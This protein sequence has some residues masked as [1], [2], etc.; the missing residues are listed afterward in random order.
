MASPIPFLGMN[1]AQALP[2]DPTIMYSIPYN[3]ESPVAG[4]VRGENGKPLVGATIKVKSKP[5]TTATNADGKFSIA[6]AEDDILI[7]S[8]TGY[9]TQEVSV[10]RKQSIQVQLKVVATGLD[11]VVVIGYGTA[12]KSDLTGSVVSANLEA[13]KAAP[14]TNLAQSLQGVAP[15]LNIGQ[16]NSAGQT[17]DIQIR[18]A[19]TI[20]G[21]ANVLIVLDGII[22]N[23]SLASINPDDIA[24]VDVLKDASSTAIYGAQAANGVLL[25]TSKK[26]KAGRTKIS[27]TGAYSTQTPTVAMRPLNREEFI[28]KVRDLNYQ[29]AYLAPDYKTPNP[30]YDVWKDIEKVMPPGVDVRNNDFDWWGAGTKTGHVQEHQLS[31]SG[32]SEKLTYLLSAAT[33][34][35]AGFIINDKF[36]RKSFRLNLDNTI[37]S[38]LKIGI[39][40]FA[41]FV[42][43]DGSEPT[44]NALIRHSP[45][46]VPYDGNG[47]LIPSPTATVLD[48]PFMTYEIDDLD[49]ENSFFGN[50]YGEIKFPFIKGLSYRLNFGN[51]YRIQRAFQAN[52]YGAGLTGSASRNEV[53]NY[54]YTVDNIF[55]YNRTFDKIH[56]LSATLLYS[57]VERKYTRT[58]ASASNFPN[59]NL[60]YNSL[61]Q[62]L[63]QKVD[64]DAARE[65]M[66]SQMVRINYKLLDRYLVTGTLRRDGFSGFASNEKWATFPSVA[67]GWILS[68][69]DFFK[70]SWIN[71]LKLR[72]SYGVNGNLIDRYKSLARFQRGRKYVFGD[73][74]EPVFGQ[75]LD[76]MGNANLRWE[77]TTGFNYGIDFSF[78]NNRLAGSVEAYR[79]VTKDLLFDVSLPGVT[80]IDE[81]TTNLGQVNNQGFELTLNSKNLVKDN[82]TWNTTLNFST[83]K[84][85]I[86][87]LVGLDANH[88]GIEDDLLSD[89]LF[90]GHS[91]QSLRG[92][93]SNGI[94]QLGED[95]PTGYY[96]GTARIIDQNND[97]KINTEDQIIL[98]KREPTF[99]VSLLNTFS[100]K[101]FTLSTFLNAVQGGKDSYLGTV[102]SPDVGS[103]LGDNSIRLNYFAG[104]DYWSPSNPEARFPRSSRAAAATPPIYANRNFVRLQDVTLSYRFEGGLLRRLN[105]ENLSVYLNGKN[106][107]T[108]TDWEGWDPE[109]GQGFTDSGRPVLRG[110]TFGLNVTF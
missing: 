36:K 104:M 35:Q 12:K 70:K 99:R 23:G 14:N 50:F 109:T 11:E 24:S 30:A 89:N 75:Y 34:G 63:L 68:E 26:G 90:I 51:N 53:Q 92:Y 42:N 3:Q 54:D 95:I 55:S 52:P 44:I 9:M 8:Y 48:N 88:D 45:L 29:T 100:Y 73:G 28:Q 31:I 61:E 13:L 84:N 21:N 10:G 7:I 76:G 4:E 43:K 81:I 101:N 66:N 25:I 37:N 106:L 67:A 74:A 107:V 96:P 59:F 83:N 58:N 22:Y 19:N 93:Q 65:A 40:S 64:S 80:G 110:Y 87:S 33:T 6:V 97:G 62:G 103:V 20:N 27:Y 2:S 102:I 94:Y 98:G 32:G 41:S 79:N 49:R 16:V 71:Q 105:L 78:L 5:T 1:V 46:L 56:D 60:G 77:R 47:K 91:I 86:V 85:K 57:A 82:F 17:P 15:G 108:W 72:A 69:E 38:W 39:Q 18:G